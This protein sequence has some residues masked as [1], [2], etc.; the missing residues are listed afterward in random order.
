MQMDDNES[1]HMHSEDQTA[2]QDPSEHNGCECG[3]N[4]K[5]NCSVSGCS[6]AALINIV[7]VDTIYLSN[8]MHHTIEILTVPPDP[9]LLFRPPISL[10]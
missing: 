8:T 5:I 4:G 2:H 7:E 9:N 10:S 1:I 6:V 3:C